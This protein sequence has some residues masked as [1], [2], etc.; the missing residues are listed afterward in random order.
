MENEL[1]LHEYFE[2]PMALIPARDDKILIN[3]QIYD[4]KNFLQQITKYI[5]N[6][7]S[8]LDCKIL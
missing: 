3:M 2:S 6:D 4:E 7:I 5:K 1:P 8:Y